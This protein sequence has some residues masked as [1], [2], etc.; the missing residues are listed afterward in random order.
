MVCSVHLI[1]EGPN[2]INWALLELTLSLGGSTIVQILIAERM[3]END[4]DPAGEV[5]PKRLT[6]THESR[7]KIICECKGSD[8]R[9]RAN[10]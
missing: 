5:R 9:R 6:K 10:R 1:Q 4:D 7:G 2:S 8:S 3:D